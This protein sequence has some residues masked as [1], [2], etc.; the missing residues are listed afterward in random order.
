MPAFVPSSTSYQPGSGFTPT[1]DYGTRPKPNGST[2]EYHPGVDFS[3]ASGTTIPAATGGIVIYSGYNDGGYG[4]TVVVESYNSSGGKFYTLYGHMN[5]NQMPTLGT[6]VV[7]GST[8]GEVGRTGLSTGPHL[9]FEV[10]TGNAPIAHGWGGPLGIT[11]SQQQY[12]YDPQ[13]FNDWSPAGVFKASYGWGGVTGYADVADPT[14]DDSLWA[15]T[16]TDNGSARIEHTFTGP[17]NYD[18]FSITGNAG[19]LYADNDEV[20]VD[21]F[22]SVSIFGSNN[23]IYLNENGQ[24]TSTG[25][26]NIMSLAD[27]TTVN[28][29]GGN[30]YVDVWSTATSFFA[31][32]YRSTYSPNDSIYDDAG[33]LLNGIFAMIYGGNSTKGDFR[34]PFYIDPTTPHRGDGDGDD[35]VVV[36]IHHIV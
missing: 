12:R 14:G 24:I 6:P 32:G 26:Q 18:I 30:N 4:N 33:D 36:G 31:N 10:L 15:Q 27:Y 19:A 13:D 2:K 7:P 5:G 25:Q 16:V 28:V 21:P 1:S 22:G 3:A 9:H 8:I 23:D 17:Y 35:V 20:I 29:N 34:T 11:S